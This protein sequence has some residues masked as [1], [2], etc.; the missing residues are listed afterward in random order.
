M[1]QE[2]KESN[3][4]YLMLFLAC[5]FG[6][7]FFMIGGFDLISGHDMTR[8][9]VS[10][11]KADMRS[12]TTA[13]E[14]YFVDYEAYPPWTQSRYRIDWHS[15]VPVP[16]FDSRASITTPVAYIAAL[17]RDPFSPDEKNP[18]TFAYWSCGID[19]ILWSCGPDGDFDIYHPDL[20]A[21]ALSTT[22][23]KEG[24]TYTLL[25]KKAAEEYLLPLTYDP[26]NGSESD[27]DVW[28]SILPY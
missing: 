9:R 12:L 7:F 11:A 10:R 26:T 23:T 27:G 1:A 17:P 15:S 14:S 5:V 21:K 22:T 16:S 13:V 28:F 24:T 18:D 4:L 20:E 2:K 6:V 25:D 3:P 19:Y 8:P